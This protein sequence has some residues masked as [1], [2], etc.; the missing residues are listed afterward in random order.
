MI[1]YNLI[2]AHI[3]N[4]FYC[5]LRYILIFTNMHINSILF[6]ITNMDID[7]SKVLNSDNYGHGFID[8]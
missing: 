1:H 8:I 3:F 2:Y 5:I 7:L 6:V 4:L